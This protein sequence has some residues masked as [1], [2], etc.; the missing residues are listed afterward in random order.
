MDRLGKCIVG[1]GCACVVQVTP[2]TVEVTL[3]RWDNINNDFQFKNKLGKALRRYKDKRVY[4]RQK[5]SGWKFSSLMG[6]VPDNL[7]LVPEHKNIE[8]IE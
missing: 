2:P 8:S 4:V 5:Y 1:I 3:C 7:G 6:R